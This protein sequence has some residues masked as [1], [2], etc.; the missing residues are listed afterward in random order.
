MKIL[1]IDSSGL[2]ASVALV[3][4]EILRGEFTVD[5]GLTHSQTSMPMIARVLLGI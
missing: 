4:D 2:V 1:A 3:E 5:N